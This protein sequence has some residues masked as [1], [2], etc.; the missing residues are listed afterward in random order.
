MSN[1]FPSTFILWFYQCSL[2]QFSWIRTVSR[3]LVRIFVDISLQIKT[4]APFLIL[5]STWFCGSVR[6]TTK[7]TQILIVTVNDD[8]IIVVGVECKGEKQSV[9]WRTYK[10][11][12]KIIDCF[13]T[14]PL[15]ICIQSDFFFRIVC[16][17]FF[18]NR[19]THYFTS[20][21]YCF[22]L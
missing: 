20:S 8:K 2:A 22:Y 11:R 21:S 1:V 16:F 13:E 15:W 17:N 14:H 3:I 12:K 10:R 5:M 18:L 6:L 9:V 7:Y 4:V 19:Y